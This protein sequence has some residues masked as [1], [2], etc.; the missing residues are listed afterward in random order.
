MNDQRAN[1]GSFASSAE[2]DAAVRDR[3]SELVRELMAAGVSRAHI[4]ASLARVI[5]HDA[6]K[7]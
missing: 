5:K 1:L 6:R 2:L 3:H 4:V 7:L